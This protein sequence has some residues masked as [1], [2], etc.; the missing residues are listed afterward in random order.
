MQVYDGTRAW[1]RDPNGTTTC[2]NAVL[3]DFENGLRRDTIAVLLAAVDGQVRVRRLPDMKDDDGVV[4]QALE[5]SGADLEP[6][7][8]YIDPATGLVVEADLRRRRL[9]HAA[10]RRE[11]QRLPPVDGVQIAFR[12]E[13]RASAASQ[14]S[15]ARS[16]T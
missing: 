14:S 4:R 7:V 1:V 11:L 2:P 9:G 12:R 8:M 5:F 3:R 15:N 13:R 10:R 16:P 6:M